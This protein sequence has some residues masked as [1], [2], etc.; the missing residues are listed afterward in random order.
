SQTGF[1]T[2]Y[3]YDGL[4]RLTNVSQSAQ[5]AHPQAR[6][7][8]YDGLSRMTSE[9]NPESGSTTYTYDSY[10]SPG[11][12]G[13]HTSEPG[14]LMLKTNA[15]A[16]TVCYVYDQIHRVTSTASSIAGNPCKRFRYDL[17]SN[18]LYSQPAGFNATGANLLGQMV[19]AETD[20]CTP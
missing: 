15:D 12:C 18:A 14:D 8:A 4:D 11:V 19:E 9:S 5:S 3:T 6:T 7:F 2:K 10:P 20:T 13:G 16:T 17:V 1:W